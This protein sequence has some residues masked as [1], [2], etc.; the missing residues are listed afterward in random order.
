MGWKW[1]EFTLL[2]QSLGLG[3]LERSLPMAMVSD[4]PTWFQG[5]APHVMAE[6]IEPLWLVT[7]GARRYTTSVTVWMSLVVQR[8]GK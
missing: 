7:D 3:S 4:V 8:A 1:I 6:R 5:D 2:E